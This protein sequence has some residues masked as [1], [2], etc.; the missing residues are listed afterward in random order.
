MRA[1]T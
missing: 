1:H